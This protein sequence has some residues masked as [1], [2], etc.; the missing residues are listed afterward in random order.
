M[1]LAALT[2][3]AAP[4]STPGID[5][6][7]YGAIGILLL[8]AIAGLVKM[9]LRQTKLADDATAQ[10]VELNKWARE[11]AIPALIAATEAI[12]AHA[13]IDR[14]LLVELRARRT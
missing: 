4:A 1:L 7:Q 6:A 2:Y 9:Y 14:E 11:E 13:E 12:K 8:M 5:L 10:N 3:S